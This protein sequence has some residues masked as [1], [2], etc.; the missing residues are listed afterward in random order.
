[1][2]FIK[3]REESVD[4]VEERKGRIKKISAAVVA[5]WEFG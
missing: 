1:L 5:R 4:F 3:R 2:V